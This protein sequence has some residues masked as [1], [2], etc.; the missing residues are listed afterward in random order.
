MF[1]QILLSPQ[2]K[3][4]YALPHE[5]PNNLCPRHVRRWAG[6]CAHTRK[7]DLASYEIRKYEE[8]LKTLY[9]TLQPSLRP[10]MKILS[11]LAKIS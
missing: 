8:T 9:K 3:G 6:L 5:F 11:V 1:Q 2:V 7:K 10:K 4:G